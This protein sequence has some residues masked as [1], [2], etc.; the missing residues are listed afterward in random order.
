[1]TARL[2]EKTIDALLEQL[3]DNDEFRAQFQRNPREA[4]RS[5]QTGDDAVDSLS[6]SPIPNLA[7]KEGFRRARGVVRKQLMESMA[8]FQPITL[9]IPRA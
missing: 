7:P 2:N 4:T 9:D 3:S 6:E 8:P 1:M 5:L